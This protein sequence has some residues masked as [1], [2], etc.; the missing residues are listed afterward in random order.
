MIDLICGARPNFMKVDSIIRGLSEKVRLVHTG[1]H[2]DYSM[3]GSFFDQLGLPKPDINLGVGSS[4]ITVQTADIMKAYEPVFLQGKPDAVVVVGDVNSTLACVLTAVRYGTPTVHV[5]AGLRSFDR[6]M[7][8]EINRLLTDQ[9]SDLLLITSRE[10]RENLLR[11]GRPDESIVMVGNPMIDTLLRL[12]PDA[13]H[14]NVPEGRFGLVTLHRPGNVDDRELL[15]SILDAL[16]KLFP[17]S[18]MFPAHPRTL[19]N[20]QRWDLESR[21]PKN[22]TMVKP[23]D[24][25]AF[26]RHQQAAEVVITDSGGVQEETS[27]MGVPCVTVRPNTER[28]ITCTLGTNVLCPDPVGIPEAVRKQIEKRPVIPPVIPMWDGDAGARIAG[29]IERILK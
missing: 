6:T 24:Y 14:K 23:M 17:L 16:G 2:Y 25:L 27:V 3:S 10:A 1:Q 21:V 13:A 7:P 19:K 9:I 11:E 4:T 12:L 5:E 29:E 26:I 8:E 18:L 15:G 22:L 28:P 20:I